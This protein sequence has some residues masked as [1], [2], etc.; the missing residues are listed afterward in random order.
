MYLSMINN[1]MAET[2]NKTNHAVRRL[3]VINT[4]FM[5]LT[6]LAGVGGMSEWSMMTGPS[7]WRISYPVFLL[8]MVLIGA[9]NW[10]ILKWVESR[11]GDKG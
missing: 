5:P 2:A 11:R 1:R 7:H 3:T 10:Y 6:L 8:G 4:V 9:V